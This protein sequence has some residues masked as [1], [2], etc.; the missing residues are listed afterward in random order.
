MAPTRTRV[1]VSDLVRLAPLTPVF[2]ASSMSPQNPSP[3]QSLFAHFTAALLPTLPPPPYGPA[4]MLTGG[5]H[6][7]SLIA[8]SLRS[9][10]CHLAGIGRPSA[11]VPDLPRRV[12]LN[13]ELDASK[14]RIA[15]DIPH[16][17]AARRLLNAQLFAPKPAAPAPAPEPGRHAGAEHECTCGE[18]EAIEIARANAGAGVKLVGAGIGTTWHEWQMARM[19]RGEE[20]DPDL[21]WFRG[22]AT[23]TLWQTVCAGGPVNWLKRWY[24][25][26][27]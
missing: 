21:D 22:L 7:R 14:A 27:W 17:A 4:I 25:K 10:A 9:R 18:N 8:S 24:G 20:P 12:L 26:D 11:V 13:R 16:E 6:D 2:T 3:R 19:G 23:E 5:L 15:Y 1:S